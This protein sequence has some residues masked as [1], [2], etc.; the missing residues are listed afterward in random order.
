LFEALRAGMGAEMRFSELIEEFEEH[1]RSEP[2]PEIFWKLA[3][4]LFTKVLED[5]LHTEAVNELLAGIRDRDLPV[6]AHH[7]AGQFIALHTSPY[8]S[9]AIIFHKSP[10]R[11][12]YLSPVDAI[13]ARIGGDDLEVARFVC[14]QPDR[15]D[16]LQ[17][18]LELVGQ[19]AVAAPTGTVFN[20]HGRCEILDWRTAGSSSRPGVTL[21]VNSGLLADFE[22]AFDRVT[23]KPVGLSGI[24]PIQSNLT[25]IFSL[26]AAAGDRASI[27]HLRPFLDC[28]QHFLRWQAAQAIAAID[29]D[30]GRTSVAALVDDAHVEVRVAARRSLDQLAAA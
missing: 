1:I 2:A 15:F 28:S 20:R 13:Q 25:T 4:E 5:R 21:R 8:S 30:E 10:T 6:T 29:A 23:R 11:F 24:D 9:W 22:W 12:L 17:P 19:E 18:D 14:R 26:L 7:T 3:P 16:I 27:E